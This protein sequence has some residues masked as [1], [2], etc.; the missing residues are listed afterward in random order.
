MI[1]VGSLVVLG[2]GVPMW[3]SPVMMRPVAF[4]VKDFG[5]VGDGVTLNTEAFVRAVSAISKFG[6]KGGAQL[7]VPPGLWLTAPFNL[8]SHMTLFLAQDAV[9]LGI[10]VGF[11]PHASVCCC[12]RIITIK[13][14]ANRQFSPEI[15]DCYQ[16]SH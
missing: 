10:Q 14:R 11:F 1:N 12:F 7:N 16:F 3:D 9:I 4:N 2:E 13:S 6:D 8:T 5:G 15:V